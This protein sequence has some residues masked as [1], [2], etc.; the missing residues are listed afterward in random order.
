VSDS[1]GAVPPPADEPGTGYQAPTG[2]IAPTSSGP[3]VGV[4]ETLDPAVPRDYDTGV[5]GDN[6]PYIG[7]AESSRPSAGAALSAVM[8]GL[9][10]A[11][12]I[13]AVLR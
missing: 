8:A 1:M 5:Y 7:H 10:L 13:I 12:F 2:P 9:V 3:R 4:G 6:W 11:I